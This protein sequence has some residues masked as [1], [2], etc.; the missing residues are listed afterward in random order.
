MISNMESSIRAL[1]LAQK[2]GY[3]D[4]KVKIKTINTGSY[5][6]TIYGEY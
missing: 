5:V 2:E 4:F 6:Y 1:K 3:N